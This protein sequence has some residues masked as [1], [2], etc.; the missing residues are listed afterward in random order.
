MIFRKIF[1]TLFNIASSAAPQISLCRKMV[2]SK[3]EAEFLDKSLKSFPPCYSQSP[4]LRILPP[5][6][7]LRKSGLKLVC[8]VNIIFWNLK[9]ENSQDYAQKPQRNCTFMNS[10]SGYMRL[11]H[12]LSDA[13]TTRLDLIHTSAYLY[14]D[15]RDAISKALYS[16]LFTWLVS[17]LN[18]II[19]GKTSRKPVKSIISILDIFGFEDFQVRSL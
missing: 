8:N 12:W 17:R 10:A 2:G 14:L 3:P 16:S 9:S 5:L 4:L 15:A 7:H 6:P 13:L 11:R 18:K 1:C 19:S